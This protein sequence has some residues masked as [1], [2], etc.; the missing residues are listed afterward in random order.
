MGIDTQH[1][2]HLLEAPGEG[3]DVELK[4]WLELSDNGHRGTLAKSLIALANHGGGVVIIGFDTDGTPAQNRPSDLKPYSQDA[5]NDIVE[6]YADPSFHCTVTPMRRERDGLEYPI[7]LVPGGHKV[8]IRS[9][10]G[11]PGNEIQAD[12]Y[13]IRRPGPASEPPQNGR[14]W[15]ELI[16]RCLRNSGDEIASLIRDVLQGRAPRV[17]APP[18]TCARLAQ[19][20][21]TSVERWMELVHEFPVNSPVRMP[22]GHYRVAAVAEGVNLNISRLRDVIQRAQQHITGWP[23]WWWP[24][25]TEIAP[26]VM[27]STIECHMAEPQAHSDAAHSDFWRVTTGGEL[28][29]IRGYIEDTPECKYPRAITTPGTAFDLILPIWRIGECLLF[30]QRFATEAAAEDSNVSVHCEWTGL[31]GRTLVDLRGRRLLVD[32]YRSRS[33]RYH[34]TITIP[35]QRI[36]T[37]LPEIV[38]DIINPLYALFDFFQPPDTIYAEELGRMLRREF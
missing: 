23:P 19:W 24:T 3:L 38:R 11:S 9:K 5:I 18:D 31:K 30:I 14:E 28:F 7:I 36:S 33:D 22:Y 6:R 20:D 32:D 12:R 34:A 4:G 25:R 27:E 17:E 29:L 13:Y 2:Q 16:R 15:D 35:T 10:R 8:P 26:Y 37:A 21:T 1:L